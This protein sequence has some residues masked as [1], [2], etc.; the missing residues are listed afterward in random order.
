MSGHVATASV[1]I[2]APP[3]R[4]W[5]AMTDPEQVAQYMMGSLV[6]SD[7]QVGSPITWSG[8][9]EGKAYQ[10]KGEV[11]EVEPGHVLEV[12]H[13][14]PM[15][16]DD[17]P[18]N[19]HRVRYELTAAGEATSVRLTQDGCDT[20]EQAEQFSQSWQGMLDGLKNVAE[21]A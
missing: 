20:P 4:V 3:E 9:W 12:T 10:D 6:D 21:S 13:Y 19:Y 11:L 17:V 15:T 5:E 8:E 16:G 18:E 1:D 7:Y 2:A 14:S